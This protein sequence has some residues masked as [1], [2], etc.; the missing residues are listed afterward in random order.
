MQ[1]T[2]LWHVPYR[3]AAWFLF[4]RLEPAF[5]RGRAGSAFPQR[6]RPP[7]PGSACPRRRRGRR[8]RPRGPDRGGRRSAPPP[9]SV[10]AGPQRGAHPGLRRVPPLPLP[11]QTGPPGPRRMPRW[12]PRVL[13]WRGGRA[14]CLQRPMPFVSSSAVRKKCLRAPG[15]CVHR[16]S[17]NNTIP[18]PSKRCTAKGSF[19]V[20]WWLRTGKEIPFHQPLATNNHVTSNIPFAI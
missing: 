11:P 12:L 18:P 7:L 2:Q 17:A 16:D 20:A 1:L 13:G 19:P 14:V 5:A 8:Q 10:G 3:W 4:L 15:A 6:P 9:D